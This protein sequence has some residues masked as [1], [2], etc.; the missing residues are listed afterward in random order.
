MKPQAL[1]DA[2]LAEI[3]DR[4]TRGWVVRRDQWLALLAMARERNLLINTR[5]DA[6]SMASQSAAVV[7]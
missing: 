3:E 5:G 6:Q 1:T 4:I 7:F 2:Q